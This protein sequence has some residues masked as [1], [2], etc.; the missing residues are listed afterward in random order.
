MKTKFLASMAALLALTT[1]VACSR[2]TTSTA[3]PA[4]LMVADKES[5][6]FNQTVPGSY[7]I[8]ASGDGAAVIRRVFAQYGVVL[9]NPLG[10]S[11]FELHLQRDPG[12]DALKKLAASS[13]G[14]VT[15]VQPNFVYHA[16]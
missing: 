15:A 12:L 10:N 9:V 7:I 13:G 16:D 8:K 6:R 3:P 1:T 5:A 14:V 11:Q 4:K 2:A